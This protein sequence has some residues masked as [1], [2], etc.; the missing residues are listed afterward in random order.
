LQA[1][2]NQRK[3]RRPHAPVNTLDSQ[4]RR[5]TA[6][7]MGLPHTSLDWAALSEHEKKEADA[8]HE[9][10]EEQEEQQNDEDQYQEE[11]LRT[12]EVSNPNSDRV[13]NYYFE[14]TKLFKV[15]L[16]E[17]YAREDR[18]LAPSLRRNAAAAAATVARQ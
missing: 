5:Y 15:K 14:G 16:D 7:P 10:K 8:K 4:L 12:I 2:E 1:A 6:V 3:L 17:S 11:E 9:K 18:D 13:D